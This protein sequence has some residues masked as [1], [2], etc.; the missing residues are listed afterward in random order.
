P[1][2]LGEEGVDGGPFTRKALSEGRRETVQP[3]GNRQRPGWEDD[4]IHRIQAHEFALDPE[5]AQAAPDDAQ[6]AT[7]ADVVYRDVEREALLCEGGAAAADL[8]AA[9]H[10]QRPLALLRQ[11][12]PADQ[13]RD[14]AA[15]DDGVVVRVYPYAGGP[16]IHPTTRR[17]SPRAPAR[18][19]AP[20]TRT[21]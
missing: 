7:P 9:L 6:A 17:C 13:A 1:D 5:G 18:S 21:R 14:P 19:R 12:G 16:P 3:R 10:D 2:E 20:P 8:G 15:D 4:G 11:L